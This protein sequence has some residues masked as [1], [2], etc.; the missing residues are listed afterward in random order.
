MNPAPSLYSVMY[1][2][3]LLRSKKDKSFYIGYTSD[4]DKRLREHNL[5]L[6]GYTSKY[7]P[8]SLVYY[9]GYISLLDAQKREKTLKS[10][11]K[12]YTNL[13]LR[14]RDSLNKIEGAG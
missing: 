12:S 8:W 9:E 11:G 7:K 13:K 10:F 1:H 5:G 14:I 3:Y 6:V 4:L 2:V